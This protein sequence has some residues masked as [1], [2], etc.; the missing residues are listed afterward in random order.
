M[1]FPERRAHLKHNPA[2]LL[3]NKTDDSTLLQN[4]KSSAQIFVEQEGQT[5]YRPTLS[6]TEH[7]T[8]ALGRRTPA[9][10]ARHTF[11]DEPQAQHDSILQVIQRA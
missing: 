8:E 5:A 6:R 2:A 10:A 3:A 1:D 7:W 11:A 9:R 4:V